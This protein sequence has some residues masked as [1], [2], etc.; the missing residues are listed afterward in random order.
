M[1]ASA[2]CP[3]RT[4]IRPIFTGPCACA[5]MG[6]KMAMHAESSAAWRM[7]RPPAK[8]FCRIARSRNSIAHRQSTRKARGGTGRATWKSSAWPCRWPNA[9]ASHFRRIGR[10]M[11]PYVVGAPTSRA[12][13]AMR[14]FA[15]L[16]LGLGAVV[17]SSW[18]AQAGHPERRADGDLRIEWEVKN[19]FRLFRNEADFQRHVRAS[20]GDGVLAEERRLARQTDGRGWARDVVERLCV[21]RAGSLL[22]TCDRDGERESYLA[23]RDHR[24]GI[25][26]GGGL[27]ASERCVWSFHDGAGPVHEQTAACDEEI[28]TRVRYG[29]PTLVS[30][31]IILQDGSTERLE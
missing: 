4:L 6:M 23:P 24:I 7:S 5:D 20:R 1:P 15:V 18:C 27:P 25:T 29:H 9:A 12:N 8:S 31:Q 21:D 3:D 19:R 10:F 30:V 16:S 17:L 11:L 26:L 14:H 13:H 22:E 2:N 28:R